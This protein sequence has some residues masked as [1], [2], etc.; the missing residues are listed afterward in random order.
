M[1]AV[2]DNQAEDVS[3]D[4]IEAAMAA[5]GNG[6]SM[7]SA[8][9]EPKKNTVKA[10]KKTRPKKSVAMT[11]DD[12]L[13]RDGKMEAPVPEIDVPALNDEPS[14]LEEDL[15][16]EVGDLAK[17][18]SG[19]CS[20]IQTAEDFMDDAASDLPMGTDQLSEVA[21]KQ[22]EA[23]Q[24]ILDDTDKIIENGEQ[25][26][27]SLA[28]LRATL[29]S[30]ELSAR[31]EIKEDVMALCKLVE[32]NRNVMFS[33]TAKMSFQDSTG[34]QI[35]KVATMLNTLQSRLLKMV[36]TFGKKS[37]HKQA[38][39]VTVDRGDQLLEKLN[40]EDKMNQNLVDTVLSEFGF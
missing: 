16:G 2:E 40:E 18:L 36:V 8:E 38:K 26:E 37:D 22:E 30:E 7:S 21:K 13:A 15:Y 32:A 27:A 24:D 23:T 31:A 29:F 34:Q 14:L 5:T 28:S 6:A 1:K 3:D 17:Y 19:V 4:F 9:P 12:V 35:Q 33:L 20:K 39:K 11:M 25:M 10:E